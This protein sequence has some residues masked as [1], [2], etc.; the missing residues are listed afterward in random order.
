MSGMVICCARP[1][2]PELL[3]TCFEYKNSYDHD[4]DNH[5]NDDGF[6]DHDGCAA[7]VVVVV[8]GSLLLNEICVLVS[9]KLMLSTPV[10]CGEHIQSSGCLHLR[11]D[12]QWKPC[13]WQD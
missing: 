10:S 3:D 11:W 7:V 13:F 8:V 9:L 4:H 2:K 1:A 12:C 5:D 6:V